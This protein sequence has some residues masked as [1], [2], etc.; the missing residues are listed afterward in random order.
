LAFNDSSKTLAPN[1]GISAD[2]AAVGNW[3]AL[4]R[5]RIFVWPSVGRSLQ[6]TLIKGNYALKGINDG[7]IRPNCYEP[8]PNAAQLRSPQEE[9][10]I[11]LVGF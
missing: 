4:P 7:P 11:G 5:Y 1:W 10:R 2:A 9:G 8:G 6:Y 3:Q